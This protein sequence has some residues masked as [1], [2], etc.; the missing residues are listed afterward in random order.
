MTQIL[1]CEKKIILRHHLFPTT[2][3]NSKFCKKT[4]CS[5]LYEFMANDNILKH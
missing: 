3:T 4:T 1:N 5:S 2:L